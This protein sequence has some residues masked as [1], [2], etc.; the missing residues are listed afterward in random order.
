MGFTELRPIQFRNL[1]DRGI[2]LDAPEVFFVGENGQGKSNLLEAIYFACFGSSFRTKKNAYLIQSGFDEM[3][4]H[5][6]YDFLSEPH[7][8]SHILEKTK[9]TIKRDD[10]ILKD[11][12]ALLEHLVT[13]IFSHSDFSFVSGGPE[14]QR[15]FFDQT[16]S[17]YTPLYLQSLR[18]YAKIL[19][20]R[21][22]VLKE[23]QYSVL[24]ALDLQ[25]SA[26]GTLLQKYR[27]DLIQAFNERFSALYES[28]AGFPVSISYRPSWKNEDPVERL[29][30][31]RQKDTIMK[32]TTSGP[33]RDKFLFMRGNEEFTQHA[34]TGQTRLMSLLLRVS[35]G[36]FYYNSTGHKPVLLLDDVMLELDFKKRLNFLELLPP[37]EQAFFTFLPDE[38]YQDYQNSN[39]LIYSVQE[40]RVHEKSI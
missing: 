30:K 17:L 20:S 2:D 14:M 38:R 36:W 37:Y 21:N 8:I 10:E 7:T 39:T 11:R 1:K 9:R 4:V 26:A 6:D 3:A 24:D 16:L 29:F 35:Q 32:T 12:S 23:K 28:V 27:H 33:H 19:K 13:I 31:S 25:L 40:G 5:C 22:V 15:L 34:S 18:T